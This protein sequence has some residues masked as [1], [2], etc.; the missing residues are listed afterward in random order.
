MDKTLKKMESEVWNKVITVNLGSVYNCC[1]V[2]INQMIEQ[3]YGRIINI[4]SVV[5]F[6]GN[7]GQT[8]YTASKA[9]I[10]GFTKSLARE[11]AQRGI[12]VNAV[13]PGYI[14]TPMTENLPDTV[15]NMFVELIPVKRFGTPDEI[16]HV[17]K[18]LLSD[19]A[20][21]ITGQVININGGMV[22]SP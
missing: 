1:R 4:S 10:L 22:M 20:A 13:A 21:Y 8:N 9:G 5:A 3:N 7:F 16:A 17:V 18:F 12:T 14:A 19:D 15:K 11:V 6:T 2:F